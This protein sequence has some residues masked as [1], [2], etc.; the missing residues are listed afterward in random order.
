MT[1]Q[2]RLGLRQVARK[3]AGTTRFNGSFAE[4]A[5]EL[6]KLL[7][8]REISSFFYFPSAQSPALII[9]NEYWRGVGIQKFRQSLTSKTKRRGRFLVRPTDFVEQYASW[10]ASDFLGQKPSAPE[11]ASISRELLMAM[12]KMA[13]QQEAY[14]NEHEWRRYME[15]AQLTAIEAKQ[16]QQ[17]SSG[18]RKPLAAMPDILIELAASMLAQQMLHPELDL[19]HTILAAVAVANIQ[20]KHGAGTNVPQPEYIATKASDI[21]A[22]RDKMLEEA[23]SP[24]D[25]VDAKDK[26][27]S[28]P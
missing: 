25:R 24:P 28:G 21:Y 15:S 16:R 27:K 19:E 26:P 12:Q 3:L 23:G 14:V 22:L 2:S 6:L 10:F 1:S 18:G 13:I 11:P 7:Q 17:K 9:R 20:K 8:D 4:A 5:R